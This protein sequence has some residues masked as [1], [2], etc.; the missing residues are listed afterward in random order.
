[1]KFVEEIKQMKIEMTRPAVMSKSEIEDFKQKIKEAFRATEFKPD[2]FI[3]VV[4]EKTND[5]VI[6]V[7]NKQIM[8]PEKYK[9]FV[10]RWLNNNGFT[11][12]YY[13]DT[14]HTDEYIM[15]K[16]ILKVTID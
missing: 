12:K 6:F 3:K 14:V 1:M 13:T 5:I 11:L 15:N 2:S 16:Q 7:R 9:A 10:I 8:V 4:F